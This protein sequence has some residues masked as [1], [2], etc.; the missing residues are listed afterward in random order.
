MNSPVPRPS[1]FWGP[2]PHRIK[3][4]GRLL[5]LLLIVSLFAFAIF[6]ERDFVWRFEATRFA[7]RTGAVD[8]KMYYSHGSRRLLEIALIDESGK[9]DTGPIPDIYDMKPAGR[10]AEGCDVYFLYQSPAAGAPHR[11]A[12]ESYRRSFNHMMRTMC[13]NPAWFGPLGERLQPNE[14]QTNRPS[15]RM[16]PK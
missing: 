13:A 7:D 8:A 15:F 14:G 12:Q 3:W 6:I 16:I 1:R 5:V 11:I 4:A 2:T 9:T 10:Q